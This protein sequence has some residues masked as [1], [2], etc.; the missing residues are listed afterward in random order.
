MAYRTDLLIIIVIFIVI[1]LVILCTFTIVCRI[2]C[3]KLNGRSAE[4][5]NHRPDASSVAGTHNGKWREFASDRTWHFRAW[6]DDLSC[7]ACE[8]WTFS[9]TRLWHGNPSMSK[10]RWNKSNLWYAMQSEWFQH[11]WTKKKP[12][13]RLY[14]NGFPPIIR[15]RRATYFTHV[16]LAG[17]KANVPILFCFFFATFLWGKETKD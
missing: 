1:F 8:L 15:R 16:D 10:H 7:F 2:L 4:S 3:F 12:T 13:Y 9:A 6:H 5:H 17:C 14:A 11:K